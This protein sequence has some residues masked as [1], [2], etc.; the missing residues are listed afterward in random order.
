MNNPRITK[1]EL[2]LIKGAIRRVFSRSELRRE[3][4]KTSIVSGHVDTSRKRVKTWCKCAECGE[5]DAVS[6]MECDHRIPIIQLSKTLTDYS[7]DDIVN[8][9]W[10]DPSNL[11]IICVTCHRKKTLGEQQQRRAYKK[12]AKK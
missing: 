11:Q 4:L 3:A 2:N 8:R 9:V 6:N 12:G 10:C 7:W 5:L 1:K